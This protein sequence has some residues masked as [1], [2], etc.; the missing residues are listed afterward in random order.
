MKGRVV[1]IEG[2]K[3]FGEIGNHSIA[4]DDGKSCITPVESLFL[5]MAAC[6]SMDVWNIMVKKRSGIKNLEA[7]VEGEREKGYPKVFRKIK[8][9]YIFHGEV[10]EESC[11][12][13][14]ELSLSKY[15]SISNMIKEVAEIET[16]IEII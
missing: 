9:L 11:K 15:C 12:K 6:T 4:F 2:M 13:A 10:E 1:H 8:L 16:E 14:V 7:R 3:F 5:A